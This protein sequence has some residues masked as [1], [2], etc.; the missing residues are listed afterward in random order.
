MP[1]LDK[2]VIKMYTLVF[3]LKYIKEIKGEIK[4]RDV[5]S[6]LDIQKKL[7]S[8]AMKNVNIVFKNKKKTTVVPVIY[9]DWSSMYSIIGGVGAVIKE[10]HK[11]K[12]NGKR[13]RENV[14]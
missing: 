8:R 6:K 2:A 13:E 9:E 1:Y 14:E 4:L 10:M 3:F 12:P 7:I 11:R 5:Y